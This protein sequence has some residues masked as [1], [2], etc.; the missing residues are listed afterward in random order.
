MA[1]PIKPTPILKGKE[2]RAF[3]KKINSNKNKPVSKEEFER[4]S[5]AFDNVI[6]GPGVTL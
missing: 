3:S 2:A 6:K 5:K 4:I 1:I